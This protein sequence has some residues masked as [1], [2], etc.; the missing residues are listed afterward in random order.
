[1]DIAV[2]EYTAPREENPFI[3]WIAENLDAIESQGSVTLSKVTGDE[4]GKTVKAFRAAAREN[5]RTATLKREG[6]NEDGTFELV[7][8]LGAKRNHPGRAGNPKD[9]TV[10]ETVAG[11]VKK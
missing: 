3:D 6:E 5:D 10:V 7:F 1:M 11:K 2:T 9:E 8:V 4:K